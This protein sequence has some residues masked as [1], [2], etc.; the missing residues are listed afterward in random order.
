M[1][2]KWNNLQKHLAQCLTV[3]SQSLPCCCWSQFFHTNSPRVTQNFNKPFPL[4]S[5]KKHSLVWSPVRMFWRKHGL[6]ANGQAMFQH[7]FIGNSFLQLSVKYI[8]QVS[9]INYSRRQIWHLSF[10]RTKLQRA[11]R[12]ISNVQ[13]NTK[14]NI[15]NSLQLPTLPN[16]TLNHLLRVTWT[17]EI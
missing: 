11:S 1:K 14:G 16:L 3:M 4:L 12:P 6:D 17:T 15:H 2:I 13:R 9:L 5:F 8:S 10:L 7:L